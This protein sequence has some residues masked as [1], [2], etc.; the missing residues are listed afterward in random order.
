V[1]QQPIPLDTIPSSL[2]GSYKIQFSPQQGTGY[3][4]KWYDNR[5]SSNDADPVT[6]GVQNITIND[7]TLQTGGAISGQVTYQGVGVA[8]VYVNYCDPNTNFCY[9][10]PAITD[11]NGNYNLAP[12]WL[13]ESPI[14][15]A[16]GFG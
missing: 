13:L 7:V 14:F 5:N 12:S 8:K 16:A 1:G 3:L 6:V 15:P 11:S 9:P 10:F 2:P 4:G